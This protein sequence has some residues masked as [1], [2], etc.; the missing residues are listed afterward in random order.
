MIACNNLPGF[1]DDKGGHIFER[2]C[3]VPCINTIEQERRDGELLDKML[4]EKD[5]IFNWFLEGLHRLIRNHYKIT[6]SEACKQA[7]SDYREKLDTVYRYLMEFYTITG[8]KLDMVSKVEFDKA[9]TAWCL[10][11]E[12]RPVSKQ[13]I[14]D[15]M[16]ANGCPASQG[17]VDGRAGVMVYRNLIEKKKDFHP[18]T[19]EEYAQASFPFA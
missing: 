6:P 14:K 13:N 1:A 8:N 16:E 17:R 10:L 19:P 9:Y 2:L 11:N 15:R 4:K 5:A 7:A 12:T 3:I 18:V